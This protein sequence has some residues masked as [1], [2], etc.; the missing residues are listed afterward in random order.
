MGP[1]IM[2]VLTTVNGAELGLLVAM[3]YLIVVI[4]IM[5][6]RMTSMLIKRRQTIPRHEVIC[7]LCGTEQEVSRES[8]TQGVQ[9]QRFDKLEKKDDV[10][11]SP[12]EEGVS[13][14]WSKMLILLFVLLLLLGREEDDNTAD[15]TPR[16]TSELL[17]NTWM[18]KVLAKR[19]GVYS[20]VTGFLGG[21]NL[22][23]LVAQK[24]YTLTQLCRLLRDMTLNVMKASINM[25]KHLRYCLD[26]IDV[27]VSESDIKFK[28]HEYFKMSGT[29]FPILAELW[30]WVIL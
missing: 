30:S 29:R 27:Y 17:H 25:R 26:V 8:I 19:R 3:R 21:V 13:G 16:S 20:N 12:N 5:R 9:A 24:A 6:L 14:L 4:V 23:L 10:K 1:S 22:A 18:L 11:R 15:K 2:D 7:T 28:L